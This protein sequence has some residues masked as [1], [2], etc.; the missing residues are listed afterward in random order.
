MVPSRSRKTAGRGATAS[1]SAHLQ[2]RNPVA[3]GGFDHVWRHAGHA[4]VIGGAAAQK[5][6]AAVGFVLNDAA[7]RSNWRGAEG[8]GWPKDRNDRE[9]Y[10]SC[11]VHSAGVIADEEVALREE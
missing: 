9:A 4:A 11:D 6:G 1:D 7:T 5:T 8:I 10:C 2:R 3:G